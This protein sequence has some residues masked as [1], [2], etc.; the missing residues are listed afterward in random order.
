M[1]PTALV[2]GGGTG[3][4]EGGGGLAMAV[5][6]AEVTVLRHKLAE[7]DKAMVRLKEVFK[8]RISAFR[9][10]CYSL[11]GYKCVAGGVGQL[12]APLGFL[13]KLQHKTTCRVLCCLVVYC[14]CSCTCPPC[15]CPLV[16]T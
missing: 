13:I 8:E 16:L 10:A 7:Q 9:E 14:H 11:F 5:K 1:P 4:V 6:D 12:V 15:P 2:L 3:E